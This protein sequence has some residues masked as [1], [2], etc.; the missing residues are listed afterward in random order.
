MANSLTE[1]EIV[2]LGKQCFHS[3]Y[4]GAELSALCREAAMYGMEQNL[5][6]EQIHF[7]HFQYACTRVHTRITT[8]MLNFYDRY[9]KQ[10][11]LTSI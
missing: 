8:E 4:S 5:N 9:R 10:C 6:I 3:G 7:S 2:T 11:S 1:Q